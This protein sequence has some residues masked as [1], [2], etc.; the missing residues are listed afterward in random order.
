MSAELREMSAKIERLER[1]NIALREE[2][3][4]L[5]SMHKDTLETN[6]RLAAYADKLADGLPVGMLPKDIENIRNAN[7]EM[8]TE[9]VRL[10]EMI[11][12][13]QYCISAFA[14][15]HNWIIP[16][17]DYQW[18]YEWQGDVDNPIELAKGFLK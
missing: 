13:L 7:A 14:D 5:K 16:D 18:S 17:Y 8:A 15:E 6:T 4:A 3:Q 12:D 2:L 9:I 1:A 10:H 11:R